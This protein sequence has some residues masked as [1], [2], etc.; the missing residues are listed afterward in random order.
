MASPVP[1]IEKHM[2]VWRSPTDAQQSSPP[3][4]TEHTMQPSLPF[5]MR[6]AQMH[7]AR[8]M[9]DGR[10]Q[11]GCKAVSAG[12]GFA[13]GSALTDVGARATST[14]STSS[15]AQSASQPI[16]SPPL[17]AAQQSLQQAA[18]ELLDC[19]DLGRAGAMFLIG[20]AVAGPGGLFL[21]KGL[22]VLAGPGGLAWKVTVEQVVGCVLWQ[23]GDCQI[24]PPY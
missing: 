17:P 8:V 6:R 5:P 21:L 11:L 2:W 10:F 12:W 20:A 3:P 16:H 13:F 14:S 19:V 9:R 22:D 1:C 23:G 15:K 4:H 7:A 18:A 24:N